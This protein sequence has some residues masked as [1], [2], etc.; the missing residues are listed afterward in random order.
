[1]FHVALHYE[2]FGELNDTITTL[3][4][5]NLVCSLPCWL[6]KISGSRNNFST[7]FLRPR[8]S[9]FQP[10]IDK[11][12]S[13]LFKKSFGCQLA[14]FVEILVAKWVFTRHGV[15]HFNVILARSQLKDLKYYLHGFLSVNLK[16][17]SLK[18]LDTMNTWLPLIYLTC[19]SEWQEDH[20]IKNALCM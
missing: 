11:F 19:N 16:K 4:L 2:V 14:T 15:I 9:N 7:K 10:R 20:W 1:M 3:S 18:L 8:S 12:F 6:R 13:L 5:A 17:L